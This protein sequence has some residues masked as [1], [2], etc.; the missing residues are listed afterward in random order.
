MTELIHDFQ[1]QMTL[2]PR[3]ILLGPLLFIAIM[4]FE[5]GLT[6]DKFRIFWEKIR[7]STWRLL[8]AIYAAWIILMTILIRENINPYQNIFSDFNLLKNGKVNLEFVKNILLF[9]PY[10][11]LFHQVFRTKHDLRTTLKLSFFTA[12]FIELCQLVFWLGEF[13]ISDIVFNTIGGIIGYALW[14]VIRGIIKKDW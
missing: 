14:I 8:F 3:A 7:C 1:H 2:I 5:D 9:I 11:F 4:Y 6:A 10:T 12:A 13:Q